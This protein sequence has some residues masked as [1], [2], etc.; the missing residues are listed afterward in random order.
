VGESLKA[1]MEG[2]F[3]NEN[4]GKAPFKV[5]NEKLT[6]NKKKKVGGG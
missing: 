5:N 1:A 6:R 4:F 3:E 2:N